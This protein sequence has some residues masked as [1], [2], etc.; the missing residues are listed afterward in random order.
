MRPDS[1]M[2]RR[3]ASVMMQDDREAHRDAVLL[4][5]FEL[6]DRDDGGDTGRHRH[7]DREDV[8]DHQ[9][10]ARDERRV[11]AEVLA[12]HDVGAAAARVREDRLAVRRGDER[13]AAR[14][15]RSRSAPASRARAPGSSRRPRS[16]TRICWVAYAVDEIASEEKTASAIVFEIRWCS[17]SEVA[18]GRPTSSR[19]SVS[20]TRGHDSVAGRWC[21]HRTRIALG[22]EQRSACHL[23]DIGPAPVS[24][25]CD[26]AAT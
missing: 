16:R 12:A 3:F 21:Q 10:R 18:S 15:P 8:V 25:T 1:L 9:R 23:R 19:F 5:P 24:Q 20:N 17:C 7:R 14:R 11:L 26:L 4:E 22:R 13:R 2:P 6:R